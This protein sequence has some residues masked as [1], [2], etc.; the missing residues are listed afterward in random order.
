MYYYSY[1]NPMQTLTAYKYKIINKENSQPM[2]AGNGELGTINVEKLLLDFSIYMS[3]IQVSTSSSRALSLELHKSESSAIYDNRV[4]FGATSGRFGQKT[5]AVNIHDETQKTELGMENAICHF[6]NVF[7]YIENNKSE[8]I[9]M[10]HRYGRGGCKTIFF[11][12]FRKF[13]KEK[14][15]SIELEAL[16]SPE[17]KSALE[18]GQ[19]NKI[20]L[21]KN[22]VKIPQKTDVV[23]NL[24]EKVPKYNNTEMELVINLKNTNYT[25]KMA[26]VNDV[27][28]QRKT[29]HEV[30]SI[31]ENF[32]Y[33]QTK[34]EL[35]VG[36][37]KQTI[38]L[39][40]IGAILCEHDITDFVEFDEEN[41]PL[42]ESVSL[43][44]DK[45]Y[46]LQKERV[47]L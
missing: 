2:I 43:E 7:F 38:D 30:F 46:A 28:F 39:N 24:K 33:D 4:H 18:N 40:S 32:E 9:C 15:L 37:R 44:A 34:V 22:T 35:K 21:V 41:E 14:N 3:R 12:L 31:P 5:V 23:D 20:R 10:F 26:Q 45:Y 19:K 29:V 6:Y 36:R 47:V 11:E 27:I 42:K 25:S 16:V 17:Q 13:L 1:D 8:N